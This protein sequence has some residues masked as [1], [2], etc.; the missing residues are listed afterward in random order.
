[1]P[2]GSNISSSLEKRRRKHFLFKVLLFLVLILIVLIALAFM[3]HYSGV[4]ISDISVN[5]NGS[6][7]EKDIQDFVQNKLNENFVFVFARDNIILC[8]RIAIER[9]LMNQFK[10]LNSASVGFSGLNKINISV[11]DRVEA[12]LWCA[13]LPTDSKKQCY[14]LDSNGFIYAEAP[15]FSGNP[16]PEY[17]GLIKDENPI[18]DSYFDAIKFEQIS[19]LFDGVKNLGFSPVDFLVDENGE[20][21]VDLS[22]GGRINLNDSQSFSDSLVKLKALVDN[23]YIKTDATSLSKLNHIDLRYGNKV[24]FDFK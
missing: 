3:T 21:Q 2:F 1:M 16:F 6:V 11:T 10:K 17:F 13:G 19:A 5:G 18:G 12:G 23:G 8:P 24:H 22:G 15:A 20:Y 14:F 9:G 4:K 7:P